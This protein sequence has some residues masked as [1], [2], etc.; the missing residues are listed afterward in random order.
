MFELFFFAEGTFAVLCLAA[1]LL[2][3]P[4]SFT[5]EEL[6]LVVV[7]LVLTSLEGVAGRFR[8]DDDF[9][10]VVLFDDGFSPTDL[11][12]GVFSEDDDDVS[13]ADGS[14]E[15]ELTAAS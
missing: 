12:T 10:M 11:V 9:S 5:A 4:D 14:D 3:V 8:N 6:L 15:L 13:R 7:V 2:G 1:V